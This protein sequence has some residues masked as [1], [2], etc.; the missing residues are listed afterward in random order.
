MR[1]SSRIGGA[2]FWPALALILLLMAAPATGQSIRPSARL[3][4]ASADATQPSSGAARRRA[5]VPFVPDRDALRA[6]KAAALGRGP[7][8]GGPGGV[9]ADAVVV[10]G[11]NQ[12]GLGATDN[13][14][15]NQ[16]TPPDTTGAIGTTH[17]VEFVNSKV[18]VYNRSTLGLVSSRDLDAFTGRAGQSVFDP[19]IQWDSQGGRWLY[20]AD[21]IDGLGNNF[22]AFGWSK[23]ADPSDLVGGWCRFALSTDVGG[24]RFLEDYPKLG[25]D[26]VHIIIGSNSFRGNS[27][28]TAHVFSIPKPAN[29]DTSCTVPSAVTAFGSPVNP[30][31]TSDG[32]IVLTPVP[33]NTSDSAAAGHVV[34]A[35]SPFFVANPSQV[36]TWHV[37]GSAGSPALIPDGNLSV[38]PFAFPANVPQ[39]GS[40]NVID[41]QDARLT[42][43]VAHV[44]PMAGAEAVWTQ[45]TVAGGGGRSVVRWYELLPASHVV[46]Q[47]GTIS[48]ATQF[49]FNGAISPATNGTTAAVNYNTGSSSQLV[50]IRAQSR[51][52]STALGQMS[53]EIVLGTSSATDEDFSCGGAATPCRWGD[54]AGA[55]PDPTNDQAIWG[56]NQLNGPLTTDPAWRTRNFEVSD[57]AAGY[58]RPKGASPLRVSLTPAFNRCGAPNRTHGPPLAFGSC[59]PPVQ[60]SSFL[61]VGTPD[62]NGAAANSFASLT[63]EAVNGN[64]ATSADEADVKLGASAT[65]V[66]LKAGLGDYTGE[67]QAN[68]SLRLTDRASGPALDQPATVQDF[69]YRFTV[70]CQATLSSTI[71]STCTVATTADAIQPGSVKES[72]R[73]I[74][75]LGQVQLFDGGSDG[76]ASTTSGNTLFMTQGVFVP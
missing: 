73:T 12:P 51:L 66:R 69:T 45:H 58:P 47:Q 68:V 40:S 75:Q 31:T 53:G 22:L 19:Q 50:D 23:T 36:M 14:L 6:G 64:P 43:A 49:V 56:S 37:G 26:N 7:A 11:L 63:F 1:T 57:I 62:A 35:D 54:Y 33:A 60:A 13:S 41:S 25:H 38:A 39:P 28:A 8:T 24:S 4:A 16:G 46:R 74:W 67:L 9:T 52:G 42:Q 70:P 15:A 76:L 5:Y 21:D 20:V 71:G 59:A 32:D 48:S 27:L 3:Q 10:G 65:D 17:Y 18:G 30:L 44:D 2:G 29:G 72:A 34:A 55:S 61:T